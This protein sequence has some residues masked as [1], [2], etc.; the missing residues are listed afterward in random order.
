[1][2]FK[3]SVML[4][5]R[6][7]AVIA[8]LYKGKRERTKCKNYRGISLLSVLVVGKIYVGILEDRVRRGTG[9]LIDDEQ[10]SFKTGRRCVDLIFTLKQIGEKARDKKTQSVCG[11]YIFEEGVQ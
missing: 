7:S 3:S 8:P 4:E 10:G 6:R 11:L 5:D 1:M 9:G 2:A